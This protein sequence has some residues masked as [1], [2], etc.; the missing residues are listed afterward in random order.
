MLKNSYWSIWKSS[1]L[2]SL[3]HFKIWYLRICILI[4]Y[5]SCLFTYYLQKLLNVFSFS[6]IF[7]AL[8]KYRLLKIDI[9]SQSAVTFFSNVTLQ[10][11]EE[12]KR[13]GQVFL[14]WPLK[15]NVLFFFQLK[16]FGL[17]WQFFMNYTCLKYQKWIEYDSYADLYTN[18]HVDA[19]CVRLYEKSHWTF[20]LSLVNLF[21]KLSK[22]A[23]NFK[24][25]LKNICK[26]QIQS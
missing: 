21:L 14:K 17:I 4:F 2:L 23:L 25:N 6:V 18:L 9:I 1:D 10:I 22:T 15:L 16:I 20:C 7:P 8:V 24:N 11:I 12:R 19:L 26:N 13:T 5:L 3:A